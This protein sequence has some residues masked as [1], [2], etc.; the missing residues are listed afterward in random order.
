MS[1]ARVN[2]SFDFRLVE[3]KKEPLMDTSSV[4]YKIAHLSTNM[5][6]RRTSADNKSFFNQNQA[7]KAMELKPGNSLEKWVSINKLLFRTNS[8]LE[9]NI[10]IFQFLFRLLQRREDDLRSRRIQ[11]EKLLNWHEQLDK[12][13]IELRK[14]EKILMLFSSKDSSQYRNVQS[15]ILNA[16]QSLKI[17]PKQ[18]KGTDAI[19]STNIVTNNG[20]RTKKHLRHIE[21]GMKALQDISSRSLFSK[22]SGEGS[23][24]TTGKELN[25]LWKRLTGQTESK[26]EPC[27]IYMLNTKDL[28][29]F[30]ENAKQAVLKKF[31]ETKYLKILDSP[32]LIDD[33]D[34]RFRGVLNTSEVQETVDTEAKDNPTAFEELKSHHQSSHVEEKIKSLSS[35]QD[36]MATDHKED[37]FTHNQGYSCKPIEK[38]TQ[39]NTSFSPDISQSNNSGLSEQTE[40]I[41][42]SIINTTEQPSKESCPKEILNNI[43]SAQNPEIDDIHSDIHSDITEDSLNNVQSLSSKTL[44][45]PASTTNQDNSLV[46]DN[47]HM[48]TE[49]DQSD[50]ML[51]DVS[52]PHLNVTSVVMSREYQVDD[53]DTSRSHEIENRYAPDKAALTKNSEATNSKNNT[54]DGS[55]MMDSR[56]PSPRSRSP[57]LTHELEQRLINLDDSLK[58]LREAISRSPVLEIVNTEEKLPLTSD[59]SIEELEFSNSPTEEN[60]ENIVTNISTGKGVKLDDFT[61][62]QVLPTKIDI[63]IRGKKINEGFPLGEVFPKSSDLDSSVEVTSQNALRVKSL[64]TDNDV[65]KIYGLNKHE[66]YL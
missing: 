26:Y 59:E 29:V 14:M 49:I 5:S 19:Q 39:L 57:S 44:S 50:I 36:L 66:R 40:Q 4:H 52:F 37:L 3:Q 65:S 51:N 16:K 23:V 54:M 11:V 1:F 6:I 34:N 13:E 46:S 15:S 60:K 56:S 27:T 43:I 12:E 8:L 7:M 61:S 31:T 10:T 18:R 25:R 63:K 62:V 22:T 9:S 30:Y 33:R 48:V 41:T 53:Q 2:L 28:E 24:K 32:S 21:D 47:I 42:Y 38:E 17:T 58:E 35:M 64:Q 20:N 45:I 55:I